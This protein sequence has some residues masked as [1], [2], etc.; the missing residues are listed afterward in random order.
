MSWILV[1]LGLA[2]WFLL[3]FVGWFILDRSL[4]SKPERIR[5]SGERHARPKA[6]TRSANTNKR[7]TDHR[8]HTEAIS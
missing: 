2:G 4:Q 3:L 5:A 8:D 1:A 6:S 7:N